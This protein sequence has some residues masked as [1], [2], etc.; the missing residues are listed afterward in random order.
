MQQPLG[1]SP[2]V[3]A[4]VPGG[5][6][7]VEVSGTDVYVTSTDFQNDGSKPPAGE[8]MKFSTAP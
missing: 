4:K 8:V 1:G 6:G 5:P 3:F 2:S 7:D